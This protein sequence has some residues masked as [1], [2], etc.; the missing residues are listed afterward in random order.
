MTILHSSTIG[1]ALQVLGSIS[2]HWTGYVHTV[3]YLYCQTVF[4]S[5]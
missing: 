4:F 3:G 1:A 5:Q 2:G